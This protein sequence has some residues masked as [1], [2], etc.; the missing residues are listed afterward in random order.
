M[1]VCR[2]QTLTAGTSDSAGTSGRSVACVLCRPRN[3]S[4]ADPAPR[5]GLWGSR[6]D[7]G[8]PVLLQTPWAGR[9]PAPARSF[10]RTGVHRRSSAK[11]VSA[12]VPKVLGHGTLSRR[13]FGKHW[14]R[15]I[16]EHRGR[17]GHGVTAE[18]LFLPTTFS[19][20]VGWEGAAAFPSL[21]GLAH[22]AGVPLTGRDPAA[23]G[24]ACSGYLPGTQRGGPLD[25]EGDVRLHPRT[26]GLSLRPWPDGPDTRSPT[27]LPQAASPAPRQ[28][29]PPPPTPE[30]GAIS[31]RSG[32]VIEARVLRLSS[33][34]GDRHRGCAPSLSPTSY[35]PSQPPG[36]QEQ[37]TDQRQPRPS[38]GL[39]A[40]LGTILA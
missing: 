2:D 1:Q 24:T 32:D 15:T 9:G 10:C 25:S 18:R 6:R 38:S 17:E 7:G 23:V 37:G 5:W 19:G 34:A 8:Q 14:V 31:A 20:G 4:H 33:R 36:L 13:S 28:L 16:Y 3:C 21:T 22:S 26:R 30:V 27:Q 11:G 39:W 29:S 12:A 35:L 40:A